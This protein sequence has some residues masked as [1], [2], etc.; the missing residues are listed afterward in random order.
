MQPCARADT[1]STA[2]DGLLRERELLQE[3]SVEVPDDVPRE[4][5]LCAAAA[6]RCHE[7]VRECRVGAA[8]AAQSGRDVECDLRGL[9]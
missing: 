4:V 2:K 6:E 1:T 9:R 5:A 7:V 8:H 3:R